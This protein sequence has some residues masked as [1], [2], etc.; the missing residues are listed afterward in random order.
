MKYA[1]DNIT[2]T[3]VADTG[4]AG[5]GPTQLNSPRGMSV[6]KTGAIIV[7]DSLNYRIQR[8]PSGSLVGT[9]I[10]MNSSNNSFG[11]LRD[12]NIDIN[13]AIYLA[14][15]NYH[16]IIKYYPNNRIGVVLAGSA[17]TGSGSDQI[18]NPFGSFI[19][20]SETL[21]I[22]DDGNDR[23]QMWL[24]GATNGTT[25]AGVTGS[26]GSTLAQLDGPRSVLVDNNG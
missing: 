15:L 21:Y 9:T 25:V 6:D 13:E 10:V 8:F 7:A 12:L 17:T 20:R 3:V 26:N 24:H 22:A 2:G 11:Q 14:D 19:D 4:T 23:V 5:S 16:R 1:V 18:N